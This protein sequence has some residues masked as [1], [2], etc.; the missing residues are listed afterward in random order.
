MADAQEDASRRHQLFEHLA[1]A[2]LGASAEEG[3][4]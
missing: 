4:S 1:E 2:G 3:T